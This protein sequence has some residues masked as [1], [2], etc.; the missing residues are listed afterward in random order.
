MR[1][2]DF[3][4]IG[5]MDERFASPGGGLANLDFFNRAHALPDVSPIMLLGEA[6]FHQFHGGV[7]SNAPAGEHP[8]QRMAEEYRQVRGHEYAKQAGQPD[9][10]GWLSPRYHGPLL[11]G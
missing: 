6:T 5:G 7:A 8:W 3:L 9:Y 11:P 2:D 1:R 4:R 10:R